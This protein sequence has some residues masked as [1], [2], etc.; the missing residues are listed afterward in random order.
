MTTKEIK[1]Q[2]EILQVT[3][4][5]GT[6]CTISPDVV[7]THRKAKDQLERLTVLLAER[8]ELIKDYFS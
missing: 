1:R 5:N 8:N 7:L 4:K 2:I 6:S 3:V